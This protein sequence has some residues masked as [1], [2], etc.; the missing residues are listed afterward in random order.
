[1][2]LKLFHSVNP[3]SEQAQ[4]KGQQYWCIF[5]HLRAKF[6]EVFQNYSWQNFKNY[7]NSE[8]P[9]NVNPHIR[10]K[11]QPAALIFCFLA[12]QFVPER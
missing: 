5:G 12:T 11:I 4:F 2:T 9:G 8:T 7:W 10:S 3:L 6:V 1:M